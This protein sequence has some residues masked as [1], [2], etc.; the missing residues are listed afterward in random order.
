MQLT[1]ILLYQSL[2]EQFPIADCRLLSKDQP[3][4]RP[5]FYE[6]GQTLTGSHIYLTEAILD[7]DLFSS[8][9]Q[10]V[11]L[12]ICQKNPASVLPAGRFFLYPPFL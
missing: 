10:D 12:I 1:S 6:K 5:Y 3:L 2:K 7:L 4:A 9:P 11:V 8:L